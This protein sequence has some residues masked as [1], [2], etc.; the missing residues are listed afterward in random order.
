MMEE[1]GKERKEGEM[2][3]SSDGRSEWCRG[4]RRVKSKKGSRVEERREEGKGKCNN[5][6]INT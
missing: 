6:C 3:G 1:E 2:T 4:K 5:V